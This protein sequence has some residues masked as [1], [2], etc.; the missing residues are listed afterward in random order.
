MRRS[1]LLL[2]LCACAGPSKA[3]DP[4]ERTIAWL[5]RLARPDGGYGWDGE[6]DPHLTPTFAAVGCYRALGR[7]PPSPGR[8]A[9]FLR[10][11]HPYLGPRAETR[12]HA[13]EL[14]SLTGQQMQ[15]LA[16][17]GEGVDPFRERVLSW[18]GVST[19][20]KTYEKGG[21]PILR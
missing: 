2:L 11:A 12:K 19:Y 18:K 10:G 15:A 13:A 1:S 8:L 6:V 7:T 20:P 21:N 4:G 16:W 17:L 9:E 3:P 14:W 5:E